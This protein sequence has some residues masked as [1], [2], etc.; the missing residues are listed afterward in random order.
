MLTRWLENAGVTIDP[1][2]LAL[3]SNARQAISLAFDLAC[4]PRGTI[5]TERLTYPARSRWPDVKAIA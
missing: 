1:S 5:L 2:H 4:G 3:T